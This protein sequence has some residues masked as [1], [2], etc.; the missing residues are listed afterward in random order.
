MCN[1]HVL[2]VFSNPTQTNNVESD[3][4]PQFIVI[5]EQDSNHETWGQTQYKQSSGHTMTAQ[6]DGAVSRGAPRGLSGL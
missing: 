4:I 3:V 5:C 2:D 6:R 1:V